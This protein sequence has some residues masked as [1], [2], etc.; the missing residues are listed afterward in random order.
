MSRADYDWLFGQIIGDGLKRLAPNANYV[1]GSPN[2]GDEHNWWVWHV[3]ADFEKYR[4]S[5]GW[6][7]EFGFQ[8][9]PVPATVEAFTEP[10]D[11]ESVVTPVMKAHQNNG[12]GRGN[13]MILDQLGRYFRKPRD[14]ECTLWLSQIN[15]AYGL[16]MGIEHWRSDWPR[17]RGAFVWQLNDCWPCAS[18]SLV[19][20]FG[21]WKAAMYTA[22]AG[23]APALVTGVYD[24]QSKELPLTICN[25]DPIAFTAELEWVVTTAAGDTVLH[26]H[27]SVNVPA[28]TIAVAGPVLQLA[29]GIAKAGSESLLVWVDVRRHGERIATNLLL[30]ARP[31]AY[32]L[33]EPQVKADI[34]PEPDGFEVR[35]SSAKPALWTFVQIAGDPDARW[36]DNFVHLAAGRPTVLHVKPSKPI[37]MDP[38]RQSLVVRSLYSLTTDSVTPS[39]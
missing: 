20:Y 16:A 5:H 2:E 25:D 22:K 1:T 11:R 13:E 14:F 18:W 38:L 34:R 7:T 37:E 10:A 21:R 9:F 27:A 17:S 8:S 26:G 12:N 15:Q 33:Q 24:A 3:G 19:D 32:S 6:M 23:F 4:D 28:G 36:T 39:P 30:T 29:D 35:L 31:K